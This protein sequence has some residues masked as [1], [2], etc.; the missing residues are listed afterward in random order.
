MFKLYFLII[1]SVLTNLIVP[2]IFAEKN[3]ENLEYIS[4]TKLNW[5]SS[6][7]DFDNKLNWHEVNPEEIYKERIII[8]K[9]GF[10]M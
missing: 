8:K 7:S 10:M 1:F 4:T 3:E 5:E 2:T 6:A 9:I